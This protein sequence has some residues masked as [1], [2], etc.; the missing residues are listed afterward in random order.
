MER[1]LASFDIYLIV[2]ELQDLR[3]CFVEKIYQ[4]SRD[5]ILLRVQ[6]KK[7]SQK[8]ALFIRN[9]EFFCRTQRSFDTPEKPSLF[10]MTL[11]KYLL[12]GKISEINQHE[13]D[14]IIQIKIGRKEGDYTLVCE[15][16]SKGNIIL[17]NPEGRIIRPLITKEW[18]SRVI[19]SGEIY[20]PPPS[21]TNPFHISEPAFQELL[22]KSSKDLVRTLAS[23][24]NL[25]G[26]YAEE[27]CL[28]AGVDKS[29]KT[30]TID[31]ITMKKLY[32]E[33]QKLL[34]IF[35]EK[36]I[37][38]V[39]VKK[40]GDLIDI[41]PFPFLSYAAIDYEPTA[42]YS[43]GLELFIPQQ[44]TQKPQE[45]AHRKMTE[46]RQRQLMQQQE[47]IEEFKKN[48]EQKKREANILYLNFQPCE[49]LLQE[50]SVLLRQKEKNDAINK[51]RANPVVKLFD[52][53][54]NELIIL[55]NDEEGNTIEIGL[56]FRKNVSENA[57]QK[58]E[59]S[60]KIQEKL[61]GALEAVEQTKHDLA[62]IKDVEV[63]EKKNKVT[64][65]KQW[66]FERFRWFI[67]TE[68]NLVVA[69]R[70]AAS[71]DTVVKKYLSAGDRY[72]HA[73]IHGAPSCVIKS[74][75]LNDEKIPISEKTLEEA[76]MFAASYS[77][78]WNQFGEASAYWVLPEQVSK[79]PE[80]GE[81]VPKGGFIIR[82]KRNYYRSKLEVAVGL[83]PFGDG[84]KLMGGPV[85]AVAARALKGYAILTPGTMKKSMI[86]RRLAKAFQVSTDLV[87][88][89]I[90]P[91]ECTIVKTIGFEVL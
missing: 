6:K 36:N 79:T 30:K 47:L 21:Q 76:C 40:D 14:R 85:N 48:I 3:G 89:V 1:G 75:G 31:A 5:E 32:D 77:R 34:S 7:E 60:K 65:E 87:E 84:E 78:A 68:G 83:I 71:N 29:T 44:K 38:P 58:Y 61:K 11:R 50:I 39:F 91:G 12:N 53:T 59:E 55:L 90:P 20:Q 42:S 86:A 27:L 52:P 69:G 43:K 63:I 37:H 9:G 15:L 88:K 80:S 22:T 17:L 46:K 16:F 51:I 26:M 81:F 23:S 33:L 24:I 66:W 70:D 35:Q 62:T 13:F 56:D 74:K 49:T 45:T 82:G 18:A 41:L 4:L 25:S 54:T 72:A 73:D 64:H 8:E 2:S 57:N 10:A 19:R 67:S 28:R